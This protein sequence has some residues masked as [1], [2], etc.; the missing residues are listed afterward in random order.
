MS[1]LEVNKILASIILALVVFGLISLFGDM[2]I[3]G[4]DS[5]KSK[6][7]YLIEIEDVATNGTSASTQNLGAEPISM[8]LVSASIARGEKIFKKCSACH[9]YEKDGVNKV[10]PN[11]WNLINRTKASVQGFAYSK[12]LGELGGKWDYEDLSQ[13]LHKPKEYIKGTIMNFSGIKKHE[14]R[15]DLILFLRE[16]AEE[17]APLP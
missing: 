12:S 5:K 9:T 6:N 4:N 7:A 10:G 1:G 3:D 11:L 8:F 16:Q 17:P 15:A 13:F 14:D 2:L